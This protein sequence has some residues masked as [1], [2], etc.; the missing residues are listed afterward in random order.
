MKE[1][2]TVKLLWHDRIATFTDCL[3]HLRYCFVLH[4]DLVSS[5]VIIHSGGTVS[6]PTIQPPCWC[7][8]CSFDD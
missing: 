3:G 2:N 8:K 6:H 4:A 5:V 7:S 1:D